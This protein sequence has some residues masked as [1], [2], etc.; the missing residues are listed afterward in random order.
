M[1]E[2]VIDSVFTRGFF[3]FLVDLSWKEKLGGFNG[4]EVLFFVLV[5]I[6]F[7]V[8]LVFRWSLLNGIEFC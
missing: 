8:L 4:G 5:V 2:C 6:V 7:G 1:G 3:F